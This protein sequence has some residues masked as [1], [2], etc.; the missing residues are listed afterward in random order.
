[1]KLINL[2]PANQV[3]CLFGNFLLFLPFWPISVKTKA[4][5][6]FVNFFGQKWIL[7]DILK[8]KGLM[9]YSDSRFADIVIVIAHM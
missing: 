6:C 2:G 9:R 5:S 1:M 7:L 4:Q 3:K 8:N